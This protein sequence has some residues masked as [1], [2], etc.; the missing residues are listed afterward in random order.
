MRLWF[1]EVIVYA[2]ETVKDWMICNKVSGDRTTWG[3]TT[4]LDCFIE[5]MDLKQS[6]VASIWG[7]EM[8]YVFK[9]LKITKERTNL[10]I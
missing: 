5:K 6:F 10:M 4:A 3:M 8:R 7:H 9:V 1:S 2:C